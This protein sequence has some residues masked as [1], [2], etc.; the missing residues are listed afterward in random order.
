MSQ[1]RRFIEGGYGRLIQSDGYEDAARTV[2]VSIW[3]L[4]AGELGRAGFLRRMLI[5]IRMHREI[6]RSLRRLASPWAMY[7]VMGFAGQ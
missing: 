7:S 2:R 1:I 5:E 6:R 4:Y 3:L